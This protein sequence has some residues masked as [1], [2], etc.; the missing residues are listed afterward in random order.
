MSNAATL[1][2]EV[3]VDL[4]GQTL[5]VVNADGAVERDDRF[6]GF[7][8]NQLFIDEMKHFLDCVAGR[9]APKVTLRDGVNVL[10]VVL[11]ARSSLE[12]GT[13]CEIPL[14]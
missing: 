10:N 3:T 6:A 5:C 14:S 2:G 7:Q 11:A 13:V 12:T 8:R 4:A 9:A 1:A